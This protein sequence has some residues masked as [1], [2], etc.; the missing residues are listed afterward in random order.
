MTLFKFELPKL[1]ARNQD[2][3]V[4]QWEI[5]VDGDKYRMTVGRV[6]GQFVTSKWTVAEAKNV[7]QA[8]ATTPE[9]QAEAEAIAKWK[10]KMKREGYYEN[11]KDIDNVSRFIEPMLAHKLRDHPDKVKLPCMVDRKYNGGR[12]VA[13]SA[14]LFT[15]KGEQYMSIPHIENALAPLFERYP[16]LVLDG[17]GYNHDL[18]FKLNEMMKILRTT[19]G[20]K[21][22]PELLARSEKIVRLYV[23]DGYGFDDITEKTGNLKRRRA[24]KELLKGIPYVV[25]VPF[26]TANTLDEVYAIYQTYVEDGMEGAI[27]RMNAPYVHK[28]SYDLLKVKPT[29]DSEG[30]IMKILEG[31]GNASGLAAKATVRWNGPDGSVEFDATFMGSQEIRREILN[32]PDEWVGKEATFLYEGLTG[33]TP[34]RPNYGRIDPDNCFQGKK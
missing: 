8:N 19:K 11:I 6:G 23:Y 4:Q 29:E 3:S 31:V 16:D 12:V 30:T 15:R 22:T 2:G 17:E 5:E 20:S 24:L 18:R 21:L 33:K 10:K 32:N 28:R 1:Y 9:Q 34:R 25:W 7:G 26:E 14:G 27:I 13:S